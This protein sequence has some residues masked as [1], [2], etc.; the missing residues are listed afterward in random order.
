MTA[1][2]G[3]FNK[4]Q[5]TAHGAQ[6]LDKLIRKEVAL[7]V[8]KEIVKPEDHL[9]L[10]LFPFKDVPTDDYIFS[11]V[12][13]LTTGLAPAIAES[14]E[15]EL[16]QKDSGLANQGRASIIDWRLKDHYDAADVQRFLDLQLL[17][18][19]N[20]FGPYGLPNTLMGDINQLPQRMQR[21]TEE[22]RRRLDNRAEW[23][24]MQSLSNG[25]IAYN[26]GN[27][28]FS[29]D[30]KRPVDQQAQTPAS[31]T[32]AS[33]THDPIGD[34]NKI[35]RLIYNR[36]GVLITRA[37]CSNKFLLSLIN[38]D[39]FILRAGLGT[40]ANSGIGQSDIPYLI[41]GWGP[42]VAI[43]IVEQQT[44]IKFI[45]YD[46]G[47]RSKPDFAQ[48]PVTFNR[49]LPESRVI[50]M[51]DDNAMAEYDSSDIGLGKM[52][53]SPHSMGNGS[54]GFYMWEQDTTDPWGKNVGTGI[55]M[56]PLFPHMELT[57]TMDV[58]L[59]A[60]L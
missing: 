3:M 44:G 58:T 56:F 38:S 47:Y 24:I 52:L 17:A 20:Q 11:Y 4:P 12:K 23:L 60:D 37:I 28:K 16:A 15:S 49:Y 8:I 21:D 35:K 5:P 2:L 45:E 13:G 39:K 40:A 57:Y 29:V 14:A 34:I 53:T 19:A 48:G 36:Y 22:R 7:G 43:D 27:I 46:S 59:P 41:N 32:Y 31:G 18:E 26:D 42:Q 33:T 10:T 1:S 25:G 51:P 54:A 55:K 6:P 30:W 50:F 9:G